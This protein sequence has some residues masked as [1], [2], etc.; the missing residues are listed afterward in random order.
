MTGTDRTF[1]DPAPDSLLPAAD[2][3]FVHYTPDDDGGLRHWLR[4]G[5][6][7]TPLTELDRFV[8][9]A[10]SP[11]G[12]RG[13]WILN[14]WAFHPQ[15]LRLK[16]AISATL[17]PP[18]PPETAPILGASGPAGCV[19]EYARP[20]ED[21]T[22]DFSRFNFT[23]T[24]MEGWLFCV[25]ESVQAQTLAAEIITTG[26]VRVWLG[27]TL[28]AWHDAF[29]YVAPLRLPL[30]LD[31][32]A[33]RNAIWLHGEMLGWREARLALGMR[34]RE[35]A[36]VQIA[37]PIG[38]ISPERWRRA[39]QGLDHLLLK[40]FAFPT[41]PGTLEL[42]AAAPEPFTFE[43][44][45]SA[46]LS[47]SWHDIPG[48]PE[49]PVAQSTLTLAPGE[50]GLLPISPDVLDAMGR[51]P[52]EHTLTLRLRP[53]DGTPLSLRRPIWASSQTYQR[54]P[55][56]DYDSRRQEALEHLARMASDP[57]TA[58]A[59][60]ETGRAAVIPSDALD[61]G[62]RFVNGRYD[63]A[64]FHAIGLLAT[65]YWYGDHPALR[66]ANRERIEAALL[67]FK[68]WIDEPGLDA[69]CYFTE[70][71]Q[72]LFHIAA[73]LAGQRWPERVFTNS[74]RTGREQQ[75]R[76]RPRIEAWIRRRLQG[77]YSEWDSNA[78]LALDIYAMLALVE[79]AAS[80]RLR[81]LAETL[82]HKTFF[83][84]ACQSFRGAH[85]GTHGRSYVEGLKSA[86]FENTASLQRIA[87][88]M[89]IFNGETRA[90]GLLALARRYRIPP[91]LQQI[92][93]DLPEALVTQARSR[94]DYRPQFDLQRGGWDVRTL[95]VRTPDAMLAAAIDHRPGA[96]GIQEHLWQATL[97]PE[98]VVFTT[99]PGNSQEHGNARPNFWAGSVRLPRVALAGRSLICLYPVEPGVG[100]GFTH[101]Y[102]PA[103]MFD[104]V[105]LAGPWAFARKGEGYVAL[106]AD[107]PLALVRTGPYAEQELRSQGPGVAWAA[108]IGRRAEDGDFAAFCRRLAERPPEANGT[109]VA[110][111]DLDGRALAFGWDGPLTVDSRPADWDNFPHYA[112]RYTETPVGA[113]PMIIHHAG[114]ALALDLRF[115][116]AP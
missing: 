78:Y 63:C 35:P 83:M 85:G 65:L 84:I 89:G 113:A 72:I 13:R 17:P 10:G 7:T 75:R 96:P 64:D 22:V 12:Q 95:T 21:C 71:H 11:F 20:L 2:V 109:H 33:G 106:W 91:I 57:L 59:A 69:M 79:F 61:L 46:P 108:C 50:R 76:A 105:A 18:A 54:E 51:S 14:F 116:R 34:L 28:A 110:W 44:E 98:A 5:P 102:F 4:C 60:V 92:G 29:S 16:R 30:R 27:R 82:L 103:A 53:A 41:L 115:K 48:S 87:W 9:P 52:G 112:N 77:G 101:A 97:G 100:L 88:G 107:G 90:T 80:P 42:S 37:L 68:L 70:N 23:P 25:L 38:P 32:Q 43:A 86:R 62:C 114:Q 56:G 24:R 94:A 58:I 8:R 111:T 39:E 15:S 47:E 45:V 66:P 31:L 99:Y 6:L 74:G 19:W 49:Q 36:D 26:P 40:Q 81:A 55:Y 104:E 3:Q 93:A 67:G 1:P 73:Y